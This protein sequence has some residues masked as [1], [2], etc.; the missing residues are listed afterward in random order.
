M[1]AG[2]CAEGVTP[3]VV[4]LYRL[5]SVNGNPV[6]YA[7]PPSMGYT[8]SVNGGELL[9]KGD[10][11]FIHGIAPGFGPIAGT[12]DISGD[13]IALESDNGESSFVVHGTWSR[14]VVTLVYGTEA[15]SGSDVPGI[16]GTLPGSR[17]FVF[18]RAAIESSP[19]TN[20]LYVLTSLNGGDLEIAIG[21][22][23]VLRIPFDS[24]TFHEGVFYRRHRREVGVYKPGAPDSLVSSV[25]Y[26]AGGSFIT[27]GSRIILQ[28]YY[29]FSGAGPI[30]DTLQ[31]Q[32]GALIRSTSTLGGLT[33][34]YQ[35]P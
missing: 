15:Q 13:D 2:A 7:L 28:R 14:D 19:A 8:Y 24:L 29:D 21:P 1:I 11:T 32:Q 35:R 25:E 33:E 12:F 26:S 31:I 4:G 3:E 20:G 27:D 16:P 9:L 30:K 34:R 23:S 10:G 6:P 18:R 17:T 5:E 22:E